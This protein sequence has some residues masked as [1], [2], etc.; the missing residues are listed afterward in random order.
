MTELIRFK[1]MGNDGQPMPGH[2]TDMPK[3]GET[4]EDAIRRIRAEFGGRLL[5]L[6]VIDGDGNASTI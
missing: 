3:P 4:V 1:L 5:D 6:K 2:S